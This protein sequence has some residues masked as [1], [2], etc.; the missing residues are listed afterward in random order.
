MKKSK[1]VSF[2]QHWA[3]HVEIAAPGCLAELGLL[4]E[5]GW[6]LLSKLLWIAKNDRS[7]RYIQKEQ[8]P[9]KQTLNKQ[10]R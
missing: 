7:A 10:V 1:N 5:L 8:E 9:L 4:F 3:R 6:Q 2:Q